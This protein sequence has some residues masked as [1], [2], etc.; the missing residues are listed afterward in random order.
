MTPANRNKLIII[1]ASTAIGFVGDITM[2]SIAASQG[3]KFRIHMPK[4]KALLQVVVIGII[5][6]VLIDVA[7]NKI[8]QSIALEEEKELD[9]LVKEE[10]SRIYAGEIRGLSPQ[11]VI[12]V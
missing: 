11:K 10:K 9:R 2:Y 6:G 12:W 3:Q 5:T 1:G 7:L 4:G 8:I